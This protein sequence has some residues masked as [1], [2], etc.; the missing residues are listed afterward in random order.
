MRTLPTDFVVLHRRG[1]GRKLYMVKLFSK[2]QKQAPT[3][4]TEEISVGARKRI[5]A[6]F[7]HIMHGDGFTDMASVLE[8]VGLWCQRE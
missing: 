6:T 7:G 4:L 2:R 8:Q 1:S 5:M 3:V